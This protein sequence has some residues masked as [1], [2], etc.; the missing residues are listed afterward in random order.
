MQIKADMDFD[1]KIVTLH[2]V[3]FRTAKNSSSIIGSQV[4]EYGDTIPTIPTSQQINAVIP[5]NLTYMGTWRINSPQLTSTI[6]NDT[7]ISGLHVTSDVLNEDGELNFYARLSA[8]VTFDYGDSPQ[9]DTSFDVEIRT[10][11]TIQQIPQNPTYEGH[12]FTGWS[13]DTSQRI[14]S[15]TTFVAQWVEDTPPVTPYVVSFYDN[16]TLVGTINVT[17]GDTIGAS[18]TIPTASGQN[19]VGWVYFLNNV[20]KDTKTIAQ[21]NS[22]VV[23]SDCEFRALY[24]RN[25]TINYRLQ[26]EFTSQ[27][28]NRSYP[29]KLVISF[30]YQLGTNPQMT[31]EVT[32]TNIPSRGSYTNGNFTISN[33]DFVNID[34]FKGYNPN[35]YPYDDMQNY[36]YYKLEYSGGYSGTTYN[37]D[38]ADNN[39]VMVIRLL[40][41]I[42]HNIN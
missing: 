35:T 12:T 28:D 9:S 13:G 37:P 15:N 39:V 26:N 40:D 38:A 8:N 23:S 36:A 17:P 33:F 4:I 2:K 27:S 29:T 20:R 41:V 25:Y 21:V 30:G 1:A 16:N 42:E 14:M 22:F 18:G 31:E 24:R 7:Y 6:C 34:E 32:I 19:F 11:L 10:Y 5:D 3:R